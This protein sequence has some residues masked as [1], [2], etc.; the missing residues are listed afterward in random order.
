MHK[1]IH[2]YTSYT[3]AVTRET[4]KGSE[5]KKA[6]ERAEYI[7]QFVDTFFETAANI[8]SMI[9]VFSANLANHI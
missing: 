8:I 3:N 9:S 4:K 5:T 7:I 2:T 1:N 6:M